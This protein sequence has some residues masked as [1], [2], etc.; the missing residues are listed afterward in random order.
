MWD[1][2]RSLS[3]FQGQLQTQLCTS[4]GILSLFAAHFM[5]CFLQR[6]PR[7]D[8]SQSKMFKRQL[9]TL[10]YICY[11]RLEIIAHY[12]RL[13]LHGFLRGDKQQK[14]KVHLQIFIPHM[15]SSFLRAGRL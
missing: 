10:S 6:A 11:C 5:L 8:V 4:S 12:L 15:L 3:G 13:V 14:P 1:F 7:S 9:S 2:L